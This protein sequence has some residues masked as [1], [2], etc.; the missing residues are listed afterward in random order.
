[1]LMNEVFGEENFVGCFVWKR[2]ASS[3]L[4]ERLVS[5]DHEYAIAYQK[6]AFT[7]LGI[8]KDF[9]SYSNPDNDPRGAWTTGDLT[10]GMN[11]NQR[12]NQFYELVDPDTGI[13]Y[14]A[15]PNRVWAYI[16][17]SMH[18]LLQEKRIIFPADPS[19][20]PM[21]KRFKN[22]LKSNVNPVSTWLS[23]VG[24]NS[25]ATRQIQEL[26]GPSVFS[27]PK[28]A[29]LIHQLVATSVKNSDIVLDFFAGSGTT[30]QVVLELNK[31]D[32]G[33][34]K[35]ILAQL[36]EKTEHPEYP[37]IAHITRERVRRVI[38]RL[39][40]ENDKKS[41]RGFRAF[42]LSSS[43]FRIWSADK[44]PDEP[45]A[46]GEQ[47]RLYADNVER[48]RGEQD[49]LYE[50]ILKSG[51]SLSSRVERIEIA[52]QPAWAVNDNKLLI[53]LNKKV[54]REMLRGMLDLKPQQ[55]LCLDA[56]FGGDDALKTN[57]VLEARAH[58]IAFRTV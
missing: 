26:M 3:A 4:A 6:Q 19:R 31:A 35:F 55:M 9:E 58:G 52:G 51:L 16:P 41:D 23:D 28:P 12:P 32:G 38:A 42:K 21:L 18:K 2:R 30:A 25:E 8:P 53:L 29:S 39:N 36:P 46:L 14:P 48:A 22:E 17:E 5:T 43:N 24:L 20:K 13:T 37:T 33:N 10:V 44:A 27:Y 34:R 7:S 11:K 15:N 56:A 40:K 49:V 57:I 45:A 50:L 54:S 47:L 1:M